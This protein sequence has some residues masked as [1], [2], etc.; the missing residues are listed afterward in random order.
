MALPLA[1]CQGYAS[2]YTI[3][4]CSSATDCG[5]YSLVSARCNDDSSDHCP[6]GQFANGNT[7]PSLCDSAPVYQ[8]ADGTHVLFRVYGGRTTAWWVADHSALDTCNYAGPLYLYSRSNPGQVGSAPTAPGYSAG[9]GW[10]DYNND[11]SG[12]IRVTAGGGH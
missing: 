6:G 3:S 11:Q 5:V 9:S 1:L 2:T 8:S 4:G 7:D 10:Y 12:G